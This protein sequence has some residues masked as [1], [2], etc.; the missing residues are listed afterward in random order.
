[1]YAQAPVGTAITY[2]GQLKEVGV[3]GD[4]TYDFIFQLWDAAEGGTMVSADLYVDDWPVEAGLFTVPLDFG[5][6]MF[7]GD[8]RWLQVHVR[9]GDSSDAYTELS[10]R[11]PLTA[12]AYALYALSGPGSGGFWAASG[13]DIYNTNTGNVGIGTTSPE[14]RLHVRTS[15]GGTAIQVEAHGPGGGRALDALVDSPEDNAIFAFNEAQTGNAYALVGE[16]ASSDGTAIYGLASNSDLD[17]SSN[18][19][20]HGRADGDSGAV[21]V[22]GEATSTNPDGSTY[23]VRGVSVIGVGVDGRSTSETGVYEQNEDSG[24]NGRLGTPTAGVQGVSYGNGGR[25]IRGASFG[26]DGYA[27]YFTGGRNYFEG[28]VG[29][30]I[31]DPQHPLHVIGDAPVVWGENQATGDF[32]V[33]GYTNAGVYGHT[34]APGGYA[35]YFTGGRSYFEGNVGIGTTSPNGRLTVVESGTGGAGVIVWGAVDE[36]NPN[37]LFEEDGGQSANIRLNEANTNA[38][39]FQTAGSTRMVIDQ[40]GAVGIGVDTPAGSLHV[41][42]SG[43]GGSAIIVQGAADGANPNMRFEEDGGLY[44]NIRMDETNESALEF[45]TAGLTRMV[46]EQ[47]GDVGIGTTDP[48]YPLHASGD[49][50]TVHG[51]D[52]LSGNCGE[53]GTADAGVYGRGQGGEAYGVHGVSSGATG[54]GVYGAATDTST[55]VHYGGYF[56]AA[57]RN[58]RGVRAAVDGAEA[59]GVVG[60]A[61][62][63]YGTGVLGSASGIEGIGV[64][65]VATD[66]TGSL[67]YAGY[68]EATGNGHAVHATTDGAPTVYAQNTATRDGETY[69]GY[70][71]AAGEDA[72]AVYGSATFGGLSQ[73]YGGYFESRAESGVGVYGAIADSGWGGGAGVKGEILGDSEFAY[74]IMGVSNDLGWAGYFTGDVTVTGT[75]SKG[76]GSFK[77]DHPLDPED[78]YLCHSFVESPDMM[79]VYNGNVATDDNGYATVTMPEWFGTVNRD[80]RYQLTVIDEADSDDFVL[81]KVVS[82]IHDNEFTIRTSVPHTKVSWQVTGIRQDPWAEAH[83]IQVEIEKPERERGSYLH[84]DLYGMPPERQV[85]RWLEA[86]TQPREGEAE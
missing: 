69:C 86:G 9:P 71:T 65:G 53:L 16:T 82:E 27:G 1:L 77:I 43:V 48:R 10:P 44:A 23:G 11:Q 19:G 76:G 84:P 64:H 26:A 31:D 60:Y 55:D 66:P 46:I 29:I 37:V 57:G 47:D 25:A 68:F 21:G 18:I 28:N 54:R 5:E 12:T 32:G 7:T 6:G 59:I 72:R 51:E 35:A 63:R 49:G 58:G 80:F 4:G 36:A 3:P 61:S 50:P 41:V 79:N 67:H 22:Y 75:L 15:T 33:L 70:F 30:G 2:Q 17:E 20:I 74:A 39:E 56:E 34:D 85:N 52:D 13:D 42:E 8:A 83:R 40:D 45:Q 78:K 73:T 14:S 38:L 62:G 24:N 81:A